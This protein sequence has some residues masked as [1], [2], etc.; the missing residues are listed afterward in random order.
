MEVLDACKK[1]MRS[2]P[3]EFDWDIDTEFHQKATFYYLDNAKKL[4]QAALDVVAKYNVLDY[5]TQKDVFTRLLNAILQDSAY[6]EGKQYV[7]VFRVNKNN[8]DS[9]SIV[10]LQIHISAKLK[11]NLFVT[12]SETSIDMTLQVINAQ[13]V[14]HLFMI[15]KRYYQK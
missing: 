14:S 2:H 4:F 8:D 6:I 7:D 12:K 11:S 9:F 3:E 1:F 15:F 13:N 5:P 10:K